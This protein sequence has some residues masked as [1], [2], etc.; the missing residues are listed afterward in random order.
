M[1]CSSGGRRLRQG[2]LGVDGGMKPMADHAVSQVGEAAWAQHSWLW[3]MR[4]AS[5]TGGA[6]T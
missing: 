5:L 6:C 4:S 1:W 2:M 3:L